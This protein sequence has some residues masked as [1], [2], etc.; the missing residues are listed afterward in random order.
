MHYRQQNCFHGVD[1]SCLRN[2]ALKEY[3]RQ[4]IVDTFDVRI[5]LAKSVK[6]TVDFQTASEYDLHRIEIPLE[7][8]ILE[9]GTIHGLAFW[10]DVCFEGSTQSIWLS[11]APTE[12]LTHWYQ[13]CFISNVRVEKFCLCSKYL[14]CFVFQVRCLIETPFLVKQ[15]QILKGKVLLMAN[16]R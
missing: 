15:G 1:L 9:T 8:Q 12:P 16:K 10:F 5:C 6:H 14:L 3:F 11:T 7:F 13:V 2:A 4:P